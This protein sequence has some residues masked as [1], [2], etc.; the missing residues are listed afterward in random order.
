M[1]ILGIKTPYQYFYIKDFLKSL[2]VSTNMFN[3]KQKTTNYVKMFED[4][5]K[6]NI[7]SEVTT[8]KEK[9]N[10]NKKSNDD[11]STTGSVS[12]S[13]LGTSIT[14]QTNKEAVERIKNIFGTD[15]ITNAQ[16]YSRDC[17]KGRQ[18]WGIDINVAN[19]KIKNY[20][21]PALVVKQVEQKVVQEKQDVLAKQA[22]LLEEKLKHLAEHDA[23]TGLINRTIF[24]DRIAQAVAQTK[25][26]KSIMAVCYIPIFDRS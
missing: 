20:E 1:N 17:E 7:L 8:N 26:Q 25:R 14:R 13:T 5:Q 3:L 12:I 16:G 19:E 4:N 9:Y 23:L 24:E 2:L 18:P 6:E 22:K 15:G 21:L 10:P 11:V